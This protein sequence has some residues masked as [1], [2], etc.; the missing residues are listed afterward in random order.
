M[1]F[2]ESAKLGLQNGGRGLNRGRLG[3]MSVLQFNLVFN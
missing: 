1:S 2:E 3:A